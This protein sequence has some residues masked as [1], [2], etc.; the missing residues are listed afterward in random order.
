MQLN[1]MHKD[2]IKHKTNID[3]AVPEISNYILLNQDCLDLLKSLPDESVQLILID[4]PYNLDLADWDTF[5][6]YITWASKWIDESYRVLSNSGSMV[7]FGGTQFQN[8]KS[9][10]LIEI[11]HYCRH[12]TKFR[13]VNT[14][15][16]YYKNDGGI[17]FTGE[18]MRIFYETIDDNDYYFYVD[19]SSVDIAGSSLGSVE[20]FALF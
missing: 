16:W 6:N 10:D 12:H 7:I 3:F 14:V 9:G 17:K 11:I 19:E 13:L 4:P 2:N 18:I 1:K 20:D 15:V 8:E 5:E